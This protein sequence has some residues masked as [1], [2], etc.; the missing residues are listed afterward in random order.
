MWDFI[1]VIIG[2]TI[3]GIIGLVVFVV[4]FLLSPVNPDEV[5]EG[6]PAFPVIGIVVLVICLIL[7]LKEK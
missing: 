1:K 6:L 4:S 7:D 3:M 2:L 5:A